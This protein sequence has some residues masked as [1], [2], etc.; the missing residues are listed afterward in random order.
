MNRII[1]IGNGFD[2]AHG[3][4]TS[5]RDFIDDFWETEKTQLIK[6]AQAG[7]KNIIENDVIKTRGIYGILR[8][9]L[10]NENL[11]GYNWFKSIPS[12][13]ITYK[14]VFLRDISNN[15][16]LKNWVDIEE[17]YYTCL[18]KCSGYISSHN[19]I[20]LEKLNNEFEFIKKALEKYLSNG[21]GNNT[22]TSRIG[23]IHGLFY[24]N[25]KVEDFPRSKEK[26]LID[27]AFDIL[28]NSHDEYYRRLRKNAF[29]GIKRKYHINNYVTEEDIRNY[30]EDRDSGGYYLNKIYPQHTLIL[31]FNYTNTESLYSSYADYKAGKFPSPIINDDSLPILNIQTIHIHGELNNENNPI[32]FGYG[33]ELAAAYKEIEKLNNKNY[34]KNIKS[35]KY[36][37]TDNYRQMLN[38]IDSNH[39][40]IYIFGHSCGNS[41]RT[42][43]NT[44][45]EHKNCV[46]IKPFFYEEEAN[47]G[48]TDDYEDI[49]INMSRNFNSKK[50]FRAKVVNKTRCEP[51]PQCEKD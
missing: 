37:Q 29:E 27:Y 13:Y 46:S 43:L 2:L 28:Q 24:D 33:D 30:L 50:L 19:L 9:L 4:K 26:L 32:I 7:D 12:E 5:Y 15:R 45:F 40:Q 21:V 31:N 1:L 20:R 14:N 41:D 25:F 10:Q 47:G 49:I 39:Y 35:I 18:L 34:Y 48:K 51:L 8:E 6:K 38:F 42:L 44:L 22:Y 23:A 11:N 16:I 3:L 36:L 17:E